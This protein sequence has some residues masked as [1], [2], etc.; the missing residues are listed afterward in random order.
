MKTNT[1]S[2]KE[3]FNINAKDA[4]EQSMRKRDELLDKSIH[5][6]IAEGD[7]QIKWYYPLD[8]LEK[9]VLKSKGFKVV[10]TVG[11]FP[12]EGIWRYIISWDQK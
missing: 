10:E 11:S 12:N 3:I 1:K 9:E 2:T 4:Y 6:A 7:I 5:D 8:E